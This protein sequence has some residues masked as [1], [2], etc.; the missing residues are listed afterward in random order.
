M[1]W[2]RRIKREITF[3]LPFD[4]IEKWIAQ[5]SELETEAP[6]T[7]DEIIREVKEKFQNDIQPDSEDDEDNDT[8]EVVPVPVTTDEAKAAMEVLNRFIL[9]TETQENEMNL[10]LQYK[11]WI[12]TRTIQKLRQGTIHRCLIDAD[13]P[14]DDDYCPKD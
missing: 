9:E 7:K 4:I 1:D 3:N 11:S 6:A 12:K 2:G 5:D 14:T 13:E 8:F 10:H